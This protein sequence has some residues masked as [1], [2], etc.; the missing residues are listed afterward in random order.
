MNKTEETINPIKKP[1]EI[2][3]I[4]VTIKIVIKGEEKELTIEEA[5][6][7]KKLLNEVIKDENYSY[8]PYYIPTTTGNNDGFYYKTSTGTDTV[9]K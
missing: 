8:K 4:D 1:K 3:D 6:I 5:K 2:T 7:L 9:I